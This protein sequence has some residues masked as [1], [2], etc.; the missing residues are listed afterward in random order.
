MSDVLRHYIDGAWA[1]PADSTTADIVN[2][3]TG[4]TTGRLA[5]G[6]EADVDSAVAAARRAFVSY[7]QLSVAERVELL[8]KI[9][10]EYERRA[11]DM[12]A[13]VTA[14]IGTPLF[15]ARL[16]ADAAV[17]S[18]RELV[19]ILPEYAFEERRG[20]YTVRKE[21]IGVCGLIPPWNY[22]ALQMTEKVVPALA[23]GCTTVLKPAEIAPYSAQV[24]A[25][26]LDAAGVPQGAF[27]MVVGKGSVA[28][29]ALTKHPDVDMISFT[30]STAVGIQ[31][32]KDAAD[33]VK[34]VTQEL[35]GKSAH[36]ILPDADIQT[37]VATAVQGV[38]G[39]SGQTCVAPTRTLIPRSRRDELV[40]AITA[41]VEAV[42]VGDPQTQVFMGPVSSERQWQTVQRY[43]QA[44]IDEGATLATG[45]PGQPED[46]KGG[47]FARPTVFADV[48]NDMTIA[49][50]E[51]FGPVM[52]LITYDTVDEAVDIANDSPYGL[53]AYV[54]GADQEQ[55]RDVAARVRAGQVL[56]NGAQLDLTAPFGGYKQSGNGRIWG[57]AGLEEN[58]EVKAVVG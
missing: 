14:D 51:I 48:T 32:Q 43:I 42:T 13:A 28:G 55:V 37:A 23:A 26:I 9:A 24:F 58:L 47:W 57:V 45:G 36:I 11:D 12:A 8:Q 29:S 35:G 4:E 19:E 33:T 25:E 46:V 56:L 7:S 6:T 31:I 44:G 40:G 2:P 1:E 39:N 20:G 10:A 34:R 41:A 3:A 38:M 18:I 54:S 16:S 17:G 30:G 21:P 50:E 22:P 5:L 27:N 53:M 49:R 52:S 15:L